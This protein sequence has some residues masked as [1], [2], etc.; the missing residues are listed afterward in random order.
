MS[1]GKSSS[2][3]ASSKADYTWDNFLSNVSG[4]CCRAIFIRHF[5]T[6][7]AQH[8]SVMGKFLD[9]PNRILADDHVT[10]LAIEE[11]NQ[12]RWRH[13]NGSG[14]VFLRR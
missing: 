10:G 12:T 6:E 11:K 14:A 13:L 7:N 8:T 2:E 5:P 9:P 3:N 1:G 4:Q